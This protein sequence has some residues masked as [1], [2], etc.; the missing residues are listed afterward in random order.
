MISQGIDNTVD[1]SV[2]KLFS[3]SAEKVTEN[4]KKKMHAPSCMDCGGTGYM[5]HPPSNDDEWCTLCYCRFR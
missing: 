2:N 1:I 3:I 5:L 4:V